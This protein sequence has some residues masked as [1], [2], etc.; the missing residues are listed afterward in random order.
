MAEQSANKT[1]GAAAGGTGSNGPTGTNAAGSGGGR[2]ASGNLRQK[3]ASTVASA[4]DNQKNRAADGIGSIAD[5]A[6]QTGEDL[7]GQNEM[8]A[9]WVNAAGDQLRTLAE[10]LRDRPAA[11]LADDLTRFARQR[12]AVF[13]G[14]AFLLGLSVAR[15]LKASPDDGY[16]SRGG[17]GYREDE[18]RET[19]M[20]GSVAGT[21]EGPS[22]GTW[23]PN[24]GAY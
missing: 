15:L 19:G 9:S 13:V 17:N 6:R 12:P 23:A 10:R 5:A 24:T 18:Y 3:V 2:A 8:L 20:G 1:G 21:G 7:R 11:E 16:S 22:G 14:G 4:A